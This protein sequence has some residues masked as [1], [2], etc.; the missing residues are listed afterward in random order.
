MKTLPEIITW[1]QQ[2]DHIRI[3][4]VEVNNVKVQGSPTTLYLSNKPFTSTSTDTPATTYYEPCLVGGLSFTENLSLDGSASIGYGD[5]EITNINGVRDSWLEYIWAKRELTMYIGDP[6]WHKADFYQIFS[7]VISDITARDKNTL[8]LVLLDKLEKLNKPISE[9]LLGGTGQNKD[10]VLPLV[11][12]ECF[13]IEPLYIS[14]VP[15]NLEYQV[16]NGVTESII[17][18]RD[19]GVPLVGT[20]LPTFNLSAGKFTLVRSPAGQ[21]TASVQ[22]EKPSGAYTNN[23]TNIIKHIVKTYGQTHSLLTDADIDVAQFTSFAAANTQPVG[24]FCKDR[25]NVLDVCQQLAGSIGASLS[26]S[27]QGKLRMVKLALPPGGTVYTV[28]P[29]D[30]EFDSFSVTDKPEVKSS[31]K[32]GYCKNWT[33]QTSGLASGIPTTHVSTLSD[34]WKPANSIDT[35]VRDEYKLYDEAEQVDSLLLTS[36]AAQAEADRRRNLWDTPRFLLSATYFAHMLPVE[37][38]DTLT[39]THPRFNMTAKAGLVV[40]ISRDWLAGRITIGVL[41]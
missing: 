1:L 27:S 31:I 5:L 25:E 29:E 21:I 11:F 15:A 28:G 12:G 2:P 35:A 32:L 41:I 13:N 26:V 36:G 17:E 40:D 30:M 24:I 4:L 18:V 22:G 10:R 7:G 37:L 34:E 16:H 33:P 20:S 19:N 38:G 23:A 3:I 14:D 6:R 8:N 9:T 39:I